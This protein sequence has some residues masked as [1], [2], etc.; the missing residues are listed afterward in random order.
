MAEHLRCGV[1]RELPSGAA[2]H[3]FR[4]P[5]CARSVRWT[6]DQISLPQAAS[7]S[8]RLAE[9]ARITTR[10]QQDA[11]A[12]AKRVLAGGVSLCPKVTGGVHGNSPWNRWRSVPHTPHAS[13]RI[14]SSSGP[15]D[16]LSTS[17]VNK[18]P[19]P[20]SRIA[21]IGQSSPNTDRQN[22]NFP[23]FP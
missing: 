18:R 13:T 8:A 20:S 21:F 9:L 1:C 16:G 22:E 17:R 14:R 10:E 23:A 5:L 15:G 4:R 6:S 12:E 19:T 7:N 11:A 3:T 2:Y